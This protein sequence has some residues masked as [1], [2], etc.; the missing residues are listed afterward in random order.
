MYLLLAF[1]F[2]VFAECDDCAIFAGL[3]LLVAMAEEDLVFVVGDEEDTVPVLA[4]STL[5]AILL[6]ESFDS[7]RTDFAS[8][9]TSSLLQGYSA[10]RQLRWLRRCVA[11]CATMCAQGQHHGEILIQ[12]FH[13]PNSETIFLHT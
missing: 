1:L 10:V 5:T 13:G 2:I 7:P 4:R 8:S 12:L 9:S 11:A 3:F 6:Q